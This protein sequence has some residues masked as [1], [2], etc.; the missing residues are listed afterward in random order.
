MIYT[1]EGET[2]FTIGGRL[3]TSS[4][5]GKVSG[6]RATYKADAAGNVTDLDV[7]CQQPRPRSRRACRQP[8]CRW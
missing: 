6:G 2:N 8:S 7:F 3:M 5:P 4:V 1:I